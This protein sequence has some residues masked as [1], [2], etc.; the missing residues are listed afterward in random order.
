MTRTRLRVRCREVRVLC[1][2]RSV[3]FSHEFRVPA[4]CWVAAGQRI[5]LPLGILRWGIQSVR[6]GIQSVRRADGRR[7]FRWCAAL[8]AAWSVS[9]GFNRQRFG[10]PNDGGKCR[11]CHCRMLA[12][13]AGP[14]SGRVRRALT[15]RGVSLRLQRFYARRRVLRHCTVLCVSGCVC[16]GPQLFMRC[17]RRLRSATTRSAFSITI[18]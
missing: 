7:W 16:A 5:I 14:A 2:A 4:R 8:Q 3:P 9:D 15:V 13:Y 1:I 18:P 10:V 11:V 12:R 6:R 17:G